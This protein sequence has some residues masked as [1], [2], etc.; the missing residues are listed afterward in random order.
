MEKFFGTD[1]VRGIANEELS[2]ELAMNI[3]RAA[4]SVL[5]KYYHDKPIFIIGKDTRLSSDMLESALAAGLCSVGADVV[6]LGV[7]PTPAVATLV[8]KYKACA[9]FMI[10]ASHN[11]MEYNGIKIF[12]KDGYKLPDEIEEEIE[13]LIRSQK[14]NLVSREYLGKV[15]T[16]ENAV[17]D[18]IKYIVSTV[19]DI[20]FSGI[21]VA[22]DCA[23]GSASET[24]DKLF[25]LLG[26]NYVIIN[27][28]PDGININKNCGSTYLKTISNFVKN[29]NFDVGMAFDGDADRCLIV[30]EN[31]ET[32]DGDKIIAIIAKYMKDRNLLKNNTFVVTVMSNLG[33]FKMA[34]E[35][36]INVETTKVGDRYVL[37]KMKEGKFCIGGEASGHIIL[38]DYSTTGDG[39]LV[40]LHFLK[41]LKDLNKKVSELAKIMNVYPQVLVN[42]EVPNSEKGNLQKDKYILSEIKKLEE[43]LNNNGRIL[44]RPS[45][46]EPLIRIM[47]EGESVNEIE[48]I[49]NHI[50]NMVKERVNKK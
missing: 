27:G 42:V 12:N 14:F 24:V 47:V 46:T 29:N 16:K 2:C 45:G 8:N 35:N 5:S 48:K 37:E 38:L 21:K 3:G 19:K 6:L 40:A 10:S 17:D 34:N 39:Q 41:I 36:N 9:G 31:G 13:S 15:L 1:G 32:V 26:I 25:S 33:L 22:V 44:L 30:D 4:G 23:N 43:K 20:D 11:P 49:A 18:Y 7:V 50:A 28:K